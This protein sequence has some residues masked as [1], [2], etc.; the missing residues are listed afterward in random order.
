[1]KIVAL[2]ACKNEEWILGFSLRVA[3]QWVDT[4]LL[5]DNDS[6]DRSNQIAHEIGREYG[7]RRITVRHWHDTQYWNEMDMRQYM[8]EEAR[9][10]GATH[11]A[12][13]DADEFITANIA[14]RM[15]DWVGTLSDGQILTLP[16]VPLWRSLQKYRDDQSVWSRAWLTTVVKDKPGLCWKPEGGY[17]F[18]KRTPYGSMDQESQWV[19]PLNDKRQGGN[20]HAQFANWARLKAKHRWY[21]INETLRWP[22]RLEV[23]EV[24][25]KYNQALD[26]S[27]I[28]LKDTPI[29]WLGPYEQ[30]YR[31]L[32]LDGPAWHDEECKRLITIHG[33]EKFTGL[34]LW[35][36]V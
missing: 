12:L 27:D 25:R 4:V 11:L 9:S 26:E 20:V 14:N 18:H 17:H 32:V 24:D 6:T 1:M 21:K 15:R 19:R 35:G 31:H 16:M 29:D 22:D 33:A 2:V 3:L 7:K 30:W 10:L 34:N 8:L 13:V 23:Q 36:L 28:D 5:C